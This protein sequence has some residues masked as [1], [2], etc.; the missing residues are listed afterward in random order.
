MKMSFYP[1]LAAG[2]MKKNART[3]VPYMLT[4]IITVA[5]YYIVKSLS[6]NPGV[7]EMIGGGYLSE[8]MFIGSHVVALFAVIFLFYTNSFLVKRRKKEFGVFNIL[9]M[10]K[11]HLAWVLGWE[12]AYLALGSL[13]LG[14]LLGIIMDKAM[15]LL[16]GKII[17]GGVPLGFFVSARV[18]GQT[19]QIFAV[20]FLLICI[21]AIRQVHVA[22]PIALLQAGNAG[23][24]EPST[25]W[26]LALAGLVSVGGG[27]Y[28]AV[29][30]SDPVASL[31]LFFV[32]VV[33]VIIGTYLLFT[34]GSIALLKI[35]RKNRK[36]YYRTRHFVSVS[37][38][39]YRMKQNA[40]GLA[41][42]CVLSTMVLV[43]VSTTTSLMIGM[44]DVVRE[45][46]PADIMVYF[47]GDAPQGNQA[48]IEAIRAL[49]RERGLAVKN[50]MAY[51]YLGLS[52]SHEYK[53]EES[54]EIG[55]TSALDY[56]DE[57]F[58]IT[59]D[60]YNAVMKERKTLEEGEVMVYSNRTSYDLPVFKLLGREYRVAEKLDSFVGNGQ[61][62]ANMSNTIYI[63]VPDREALLEIYDAQR[64]LLGENARGIRQVYGF[65]MDA[66]EEEQNAF[67]N[68]L[69]DCMAQNG[70]SA[71]TEARAEAKSSFISLYGGLFFIG[72]FLGVLFVMATVLIIY[73]KQISEGYDD[74][75]RFSIMQKVGMSR[76]EVKSAIHSQVVTVFF[77]PLI[78]AGIHVTAAFP[79]ISKLLVLMQLTNTKL[80]IAC[81]G[82]CFLV[83]AVMYVFV[84]NLTARTYYRIV[85]R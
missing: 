60:D 47:K 32:A 54:H 11:R 9:G 8:L 35:L 4:C 75:E 48:Y 29:T 77:L 26:L 44:E 63:V 21:N 52:A 85:S 39:I 6:Q 31:L 36:Y 57:L 37:G 58:L 69:L 71:V 55:V 18:I 76:D 67:Y 5:M 64:E 19:V 84:Y 43:M 23:E 66:D 20:I 38:M 68:D 2:N 51:L 1:K 56:M 74:R 82:A 41:N 24:K 59:L 7:K 33:L 81:T 45:R 10:E 17:G 27:Y 40:V 34:A 12:T 22:D 83:F 30:V 72:V 50:E 46:Y 62:S 3:Y 61:Y 70:I 79:L 15:Y 13:V 53:Y 25:R 65:D 42:I 14:L 78:V 16:V 80:F 49:Q 73:Y 28:I